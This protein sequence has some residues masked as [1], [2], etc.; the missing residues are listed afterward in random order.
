MKGIGDDPFISALDIECCGFADCG[1]LREWIYHQRF[2]FGPDRRGRHWTVQ[3]NA[4]FTAQDHHAATGH[5]DVRAV[6]SGDQCGDSLVLKQVRS[7]IFRHNLQGSLFRRIGACGAT[8]AVR[9]FRWVEEG[10]LVA[11]ALEIE[12]LLLRTGGRGGGWSREVEGGTGLVTVVH[13]AGKDSVGCGADHWV[14][15]IA[16]GDLT[17]VSLGRGEELLRE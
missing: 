13:P 14:F 11:I 8:P 12:G 10:R 6:L 2:R 17:K 16:G 9:L 7:G 15:L 1:A 3:R 4:W 5:P